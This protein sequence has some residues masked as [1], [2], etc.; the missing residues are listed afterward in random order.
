MATGQTI[1]DEA[2][3]DL[4]DGDASNLRFSDT[5]MLRFINAAIRQIVTLLPSANVVEES[6]ALVAG[7]RQTLPSGGVK[8]LGLYNLESSVRGDAVTVIE[9]DA[10]N[11]SF[12]TW[13]TGPISP[14]AA[15]AVLHVTHDPRDP[16]TFGVYPPVA[17][18]FNVLVKHAK[19]P[20]AL[21]SLASTFPLGDEY[22]N[23]A[24]EY[25]KWRCLSIDGRFGTSPEQRLEQWNNFRM[26]LGLKPQ[27]ERS[28]D[29][30][31]GRAGGDDNG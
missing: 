12:P 11:S 9:E 14:D 4:N 15:G 27:V 10:L 6:T 18:P 1:A 17:T 22:I 8:F 25:V 3:A 7:S 28:V 24:V 16:K 19:I 5:V 20:T 31:R 13:P 26:M 21:A 2:R 30:A 23:A 29:P